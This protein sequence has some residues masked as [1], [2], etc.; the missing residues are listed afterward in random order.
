MSRPLA[1]LYILFCFEIGVC[2]LVFP[3]MTRVWGNN[4]FVGHYPWVASLAQNYFVRGAISG[5]GV[6]D[7]WLALYELRHFPRRTRAARK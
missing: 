3:W 5:L 7:M 2:L 6:A 4:F 1:I